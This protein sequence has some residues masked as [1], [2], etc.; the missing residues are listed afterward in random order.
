MNG[1]DL[2]KKAKPIINAS[3]LSCHYSQKEFGKNFLFGTEMFRV[4]S[5]S[6]SGMFY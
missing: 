3:V 1:R 6:L 2:F 4:N 5:V